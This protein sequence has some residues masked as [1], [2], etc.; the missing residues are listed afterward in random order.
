MCGWEVGSI[1]RVDIG[2]DGWV[3][4]RGGRVGSSRSILVM[5]L[6][7]CDRCVVF[8]FGWFR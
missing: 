3:D 2:D 5:V 6:I 7:L 4:D 8:F 1:N